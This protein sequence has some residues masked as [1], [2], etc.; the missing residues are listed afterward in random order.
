MRKLILEK[1]L[2]L[3][4]NAC[5]YRNFS[6]HV[7]ETLPMAMFPTHIRCSTLAGIGGGT[8][9]FLGYGVP[10]TTS[11]VGAGLCCVGGILPDI[12]SGPGI[13]LR[14]IT[15]FLASVVP[16]MLITRLLAYRFTQESLILT[17]AIIYIA[18]RFGLSHFL[19]NYTVHRGMFHSFPSM[20]IF[21]ELTY[22]LFYGESRFVRLFMVSSVCLGFFIHLLLDEIYSVEWDGKPRLKKSFGTAMKFVGPGW[23]PNFTCYAKLAVLTFLVMN[24]PSVIQQLYTGQGQ[25][26]AKNLGQVV[27]D[28][29]DSAV[30]K[31]HPQSP[32]DVAYGAM[33]PAGSANGSPQ[34]A[35][36][37]ANSATVPPPSL[38]WPTAPTA[39]SYPPQ[40]TAAPA[41]AN[42]P[43][44]ADPPT[45]AGFPSNAAGTSGATPAPGSTAQPADNRPWSPAPSRQTSG[46]RFWQ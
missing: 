3:A 7:P 43:V 38:A 36:I 18:I 41:A 45:S 5:E 2:P 1:S 25:D 31:P 35:A 11:M 15:T 6:C 37:S 16:T 40:P 23:W 46:T 29:F 10:L 21:G 34:R 27:K 20:A 9:A 33:V 30:A 28:Q 26:I 12:D 19:R 8:V 17:G 14:E 42:W 4:T 13:P 32:G 39:T 44:P 22:L 24:D